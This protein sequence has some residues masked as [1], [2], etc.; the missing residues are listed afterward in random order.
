MADV[1]VVTFFPHPQTRIGTEALTRA[2]LAARSRRSRPDA[3]VSPELRFV[4][5]PVPGA[6]EIRALYSDRAQA[7]IEDWVSPAR[8]A[9][10]T[11]VFDDLEDIVQVVSYQE[12][13]ATSDS[14]LDVAAPADLENRR[15]LD[16][17]SG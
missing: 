12:H 10:G 1:A 17:R 8:D 4:V 15:R 9:D 14:V 2:L 7:W 11:A 6:P 13:I 5:S 16:R 3:P